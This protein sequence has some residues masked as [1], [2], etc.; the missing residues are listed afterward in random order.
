M[1][2]AR[3]LPE[4]VGNTPL[5]RLR[6]ASEATGCE[7]WGK[8]EFMNPGE[9]VK[10]RAAL[11]IIRDAVAR[12]RAAA[13]RHHRRG[14]RRQHRHRAGADRR[15][16]GV[17]HGHRHPR[18]PEPGEEGRDPVRRRRA[19]RGAGGA[20][21]RP[22]QLRALLRAAGRGAGGRP[23]RTARSGPTSSTTSPTARRTS[24][25]PRPKSGSRPAAGSTASSARSARA[26]RSPASPRGCGRAIPKV[27]DRPRRPRGR[28]ALALLCPR[29]AQGR[30]QLDHR[31]HRPG[32]DHREPRGADRRHALPHPRRRGDPDG[33]RPAASTRGS[34][35]APRPAS[36]SPARSAWR[37]T[38]GRGTRIV[39]ILCDY[40]TRYQ[41]K[42]FNPAFLRE[43][44][45]PVPDWL[46]A[47]RDL[48]DAFVG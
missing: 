12:G 15:V 37:A 25:A 8:A 44:G 13:R 1:I 29:R 19:G 17:P 30:G 27:Q 36:T 18:H 40:G 39:T 22:E 10:D 3:D 2:V 9:S 5:I 7:I 23:S 38:S 34:A 47:R 11:W 35:W 28:G 14:D 4:A 24:T 45:L 33:L 46:E 41:S 6:R 21:P 16:D 31:G 26:A 20:L 48:P 42:L 43:K 32:P